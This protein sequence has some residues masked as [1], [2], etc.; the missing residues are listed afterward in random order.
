[1]TEIHSFTG[2]TL[3]ETASQ[4]GEGPTY[5]PATG[6]AY[7]FDI[8]GQMLHELQRASAH[9]GRALRES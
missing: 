5:D 4:L 6:K 9:P 7:W 3:C 1:M 8:T 2:R